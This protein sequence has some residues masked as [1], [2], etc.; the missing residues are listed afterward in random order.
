MIDSIVL[1]VY[2]IECTNCKVSYFGA[3]DNGVVNGS[4]ELGYP[5]SLLPTGDLAICLPPHQC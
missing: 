1:F 5:E 2:K 3:F 4:A